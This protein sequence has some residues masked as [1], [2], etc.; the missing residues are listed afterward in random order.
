MKNINKNR[1][2]KYILP[3]VLTLCLIISCICVYFYKLGYHA[4]G[5]APEAQT[6]APEIAE[7]TYGYC[8]FTTADGSKIKMCGSPNATENTIDFYLTNEEGND[9]WIL[10]EVCNENDET[11][12]NSGVLKQGQFLQTLKLDKKLNI[13]ENKLKLKLRTFVPEEYYSKGTVNLET[14]VTVK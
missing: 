4:P 1:F 9:M 3:N 8:P 10:L 7:G 14:T 11:L 6:G 5:F 12:G 13:G 2:L